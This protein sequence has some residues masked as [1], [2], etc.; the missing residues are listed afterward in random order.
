[1]LALPIATLASTPAVQGYGVSP[2]KFRAGATLTLTLPSPHPKGL[3]VKTPH[4][5]LVYV[6][7]AGASAA[8]LQG[9][10][11]KNYF[12]FKTG[13]LRGVID[14]DGKRHQRKVFV[15]AGTYEFYIA[16]NLA[17]PAGANTLS[18]EVSYKP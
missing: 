9:F 16:D 1:M 2:A 17:G 14:K 13:D 10:S 11:D 3:A 4:G 15:E 6:V 18:Y 7:D 5:V 12:T 8:F